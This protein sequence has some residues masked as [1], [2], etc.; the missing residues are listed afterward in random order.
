[1]WNL[2]DKLLIKCIYRFY[3]NLFLS[4]CL[5][6][7]MK[8]LAYVWQMSCGENLHYWVNSPWNCMQSIVPATHLFDIGFH[9]HF[10]ESEFW[11][12]L[13]VVQLHQLP[14]V[15]YLVLAQLL[16]W[17][18]QIHHLVSLPQLWSGD[19]G[20]HLRTHLTLCVLPRLILVHCQLQVCK[21]DTHFPTFRTWQRQKGVFIWLHVHT[22]SVCM[23][24]CNSSSSWPIIGLW[25]TLFHEVT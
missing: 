16:W 6:L 4:L 13:Q 23:H 3:V 21:N 1:M 2:R 15:W 10:D 25:R 8:L 20:P 24:A 14:A 12:L 11:T 19:Q 22:L 17:Q 18:L 7:W 5:K 9:F